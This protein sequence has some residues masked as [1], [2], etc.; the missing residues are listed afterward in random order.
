MVGIISYGAYVP[1]YRITSAEIAQVWHKEPEEIVRSLGV[2]E[3]AVAGRDEDT[4]TLAM[5]AAAQCLRLSS[6]DAA[7][8]NV[9]L[10]GSESHPYAVNPTST[11][12]GDFLGIGHEYLA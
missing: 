10:V 4:V 12:V 9:V 2:S 1:K 5:E 6:L 3:K 8:I 11:I 7:N